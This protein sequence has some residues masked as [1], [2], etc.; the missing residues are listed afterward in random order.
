MWTGVTISFYKYH[1]FS[2]HFRSQKVGYE[3]GI[4]AGKLAGILQGNKLG[5]EKGA[6]I[7][8]EV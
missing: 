6:A 3:E 4:A 1:Y 7:G 8:S 2:P 5:W